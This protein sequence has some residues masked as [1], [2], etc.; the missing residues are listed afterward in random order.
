MRLR[1]LAHAFAFG[2]GDVAGCPGASPNYA[3]VDSAG[4]K[5][6]SHGAIV[7]SIAGGLPLRSGQSQLDPLLPQIQFFRLA[8]NLCSAANDD[9]AAAAVTA[10]EY[11]VSAS[12]AKV[13]NLSMVSDGEAGT[14]LKSRIADMAGYTIPLLVLPATDYGANLD[15]THP[16]P[17][18]LTLTADTMAK[19]LLVV[20][21]ANRNLRRADYSG[22]GDRTVRIY[23]PAE[24]KGAIDVLGA[25]A[26]ALPPATSYAAPLVSLAAALLRSLGLDD[27][28]RLRNRLLLSTW[29]LFD[30]TG[31]P[32]GTRGGVL[33]IGVLDLVK[34][35]AVHHQAVEVLERQ[36]GGT[37]V[38]RTYVGQ[39]TAGLDTLCPGQSISEAGAQS[40][41]LGPPQP[42]GSRDATEVLRKVDQTYR[43]PVIRQL[44]PCYSSGDLTLRTLDGRTMTLPVWGVTQILFATR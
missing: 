23:A 33:D 1:V 43:D 41:R 42:D 9:E 31:T 40:V 6:A 21:A 16:C 17:P 44:P 10:M 22:F 13:I 25:D 11:L 8:R 26:S 35:V 12:D 3:A 14:L 39:V 28:I 38:R 29:P 27:A 2:A 7:S 36:S 32:I 18:C 15:A 37:V 19:G 20:G 24:P 5:V 4:D 34:V 30:S